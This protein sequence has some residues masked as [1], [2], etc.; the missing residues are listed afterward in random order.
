VSGELKNWGA[1]RIYFAIREQLQIETG[2][3]GHPDTIARGE[4]SVFL[5]REGIVPGIM[6]PIR[7]TAR[8]Q[9]LPLIGIAIAALVLPPICIRLARGRS[10]S[11][12]SADT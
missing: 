2:K 4:I 1:D 5:V 10:R 6:K 12:S 9:Q 11:P 3:A 8:A 7:S